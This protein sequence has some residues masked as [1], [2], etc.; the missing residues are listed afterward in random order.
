M[1][2]ADRPGDEPVQHSWP[3]LTCYGCGPANDEGL[4]L[5]SYRSE[6]KEALVTTVEPEELFTSGAPN[7]M[8]GGHIAS[9]VDCHSI[10][11]SITFAY[12]AEDRPL[13]SSP[14]IAYVTAELSVEY[15][16]PTPLDRPVHLTARIDGEI[17]RKTVVRSELGPEGET[18]ARGTV[19]AVRVRPP[20]LEGHHQADRT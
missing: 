11:T 13:G 16:K 4:Q 10:W 3:E 15:L 18:T 14:R 8:Y 6:D 19:R 17:G 1:S 12:D 9:L 2:S 20:D 5:Q 7:V